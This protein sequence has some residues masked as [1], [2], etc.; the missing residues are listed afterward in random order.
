MVTVATFGQTT[1]NTSVP[2]ASGT[3][4]NS[5]SPSVSGNVPSDNLDKSMNNNDEHNNDNNNKRQ[6]LNPNDEIK[7]IYSHLPTVHQ[8]FYL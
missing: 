1:N 6:R 3:T 8:T 2:N 5:S 7:D 4:T